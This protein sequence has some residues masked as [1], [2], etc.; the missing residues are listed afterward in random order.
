MLTLTQDEIARHSGA[1]S[2]VPEP[3]AQADYWPA[4]GGWLSPVVQEHGTRW[5]EP[6][7]LLLGWLDCALVLT[8]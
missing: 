1:E 8:G 2:G 3:L 4:A 6:V 5:Q 7:V